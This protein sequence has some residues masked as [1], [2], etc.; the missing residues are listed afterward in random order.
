MGGF[1]ELGKRLDK[2]TETVKRIAREGVGKS[3]KEAKEWGRK[4]D[5]LGEGVKKISQEGLEKFASGAKGLGQIGKLRLEIR[6]REKKLADKFEEIGEKT[7]ELCLEKKIENT[8]LEKLREEITGLKKEVEGKKKKIKE[9][10]KG[11]DKTESGER[12]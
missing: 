1:E 11:K 4:L 3:S 9:L 2:L 5:E 6:E 12:K 7:Y 10:K 8:E